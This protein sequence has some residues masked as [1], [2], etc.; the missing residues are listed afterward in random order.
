MWVYFILF[1]GLFGR[2]LSWVWDGVMD[3]LGQCIDLSLCIGKRLCRILEYE[4]SGTLFPWQNSFN[5]HPWLASDIRGRSLMLCITLRVLDPLS[6]VFLMWHINL[7]PT[8][9]Y[10]DHICALGDACC[11]MK[12]WLLGYWGFISTCAVLAQL[13]FCRDLCT[14]LQNG[15]YGKT[16]TLVL[17]W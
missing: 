8:S 11:I 9:W 6:K 2:A 12:S 16:K 15:T 13:V 10:L 5:V 7:L 4:H 17:L 14:G 1:F 3:Y